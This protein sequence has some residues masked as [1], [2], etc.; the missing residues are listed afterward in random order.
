MGLPGWLIVHSLPSGSFSVEMQGHAG[1][2][3]SGDLSGFETFDQTGCFPTVEAMTI[4]VGRL[5]AAN[6][7]T[8]WPTSLG[9]FRGAKVSLIGSEVA[10]RGEARPPPLLR[11]LS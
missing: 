7:A 5:R 11:S 6:T 2:V 8:R 4:H 1:G 10:A 9:S 3:L